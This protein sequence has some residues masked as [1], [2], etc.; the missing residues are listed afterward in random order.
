VKDLR[1]PTTADERRAAATV[2]EGTPL[3]Q[4]APTVRCLVDSYLTNPNAASL[5]TAKAALTAYWRGFRTGMGGPK[6]TTIRH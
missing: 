1:I 5:K 3:D 6:R 2:A 4:M